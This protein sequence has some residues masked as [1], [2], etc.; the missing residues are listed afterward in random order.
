MELLPDFSTQ[1]IEQ[2]PT[3]PQ[4]QAA[5]WLTLDNNFPRYADGILLQRFALATIFFA[6]DGPNWT[7]RTGWLDP[8]D[9]C[10]WFDSLAP[11]G[12]DICLNTRRT[13][14]NLADNN[15]VGTLPPEIGILSDLEYLV[16]YQNRIGGQLPSEIGLLTALRT[17]IVFSNPWTGT[18][19]RTVGLMT[20]LET[21]DIDFSS[22]DSK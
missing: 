3:G 4:A 20:E 2:D 22:M 9:D 16:L 15:L 5:Q 13:T 1:A 21:F 14:L 12:Q 7:N 6:T 17:F 18:I 10:N 19:P 11:F 8:T